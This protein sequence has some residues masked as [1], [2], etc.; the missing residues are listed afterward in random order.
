MGRGQ[1]GLGR[2]KRRLGIVLIE[3]YKV[4]FS[5]VYVQST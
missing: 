5:M 2:G 3:G 4:D 1:R